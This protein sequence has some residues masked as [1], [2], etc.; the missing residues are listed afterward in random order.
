MGR[1]AIA[2]SPAQWYFAPNVSRQHKFWD[3]WVAF[4][5]KQYAC[6]GAKASEEA[7]REDRWR[8]RGEGVGCAGEAA[9]EVG[10]SS[11]TGCWS[12]QLCLC[13]P[14]ADECCQGATRAGPKPRQDGRSAEVP[15][16]PQHAPTVRLLPYCLHCQLHRQEV[17]LCQSKR[18]NLCL[19]RL[20]HW[21]VCW[22]RLLDP[23]GDQ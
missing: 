22:H 17:R 16:L 14:L 21:D 7:S 6:Q 20:P 10:G 23:L 4:A 5:R 15:H 9:E 18:C 1:V 3:F 12:C 8:C 11:Y 19:R 13:L 2:H